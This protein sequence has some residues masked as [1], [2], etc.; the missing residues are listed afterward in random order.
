MGEDVLER[1]HQARM[2]HEERLLRLRYKAKKMLSQAKSQDISHIKQVQDIQQKVSSSRKR[3]L[4]RD[5]ALKV[6]RDSIKKQLKEEERYTVWDLKTN[7]NDEPIRLNPREVLKE[8][9]RLDL[10]TTDNN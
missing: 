1:A 4:T 8:Q 5:V 9:I 6:E 10:S 7:R 3:N 2:R